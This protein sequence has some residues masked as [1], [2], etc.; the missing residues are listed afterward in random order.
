[1]QSINCETNTI[2]VSSEQDVKPKRSGRHQKRD[3]ESDPAR[4]KECLLKKQKKVA[5]KLS[6]LDPSETRKAQRLQGKLAVLNAKVESLS[7]VKLEVQ[8][9]DRMDDAPKKEEVSVISTAAIPDTVLQPSP[10]VEDTTTTYTAPVVAGAPVVAIAPAVEPSALK[11][12]SLKYLSLRKDLKQEKLRIK[13]LA[14]VLYAVKLLSRTNNSEIAP[15]VLIS[16]EQVNKTKSDLDL[17]R[18]QLSEKRHLIKEQ[19]H[20]VR[21]LIRLYRQMNP[22]RKHGKHGRKHCKE[23]KEDKKEKKYRKCKKDCKDYKD[24]K[25]QKDYKDKKDHKDKKD[26]KEKR[27]RKERRDGKCDESHLKGRRKCSF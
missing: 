8:N 25:D 4:N 5:D 19:A 12:A 24:K 27:E 20:A 15:Q 11:E 3:R 17:A 10:K 2:V 7:A 18:K 1:M 26:F 6:A 23:G 9:T 16:D 21:D 14:A 22:H 13:N